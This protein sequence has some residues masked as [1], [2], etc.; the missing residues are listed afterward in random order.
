M[1]LT[2]QEE[3]QGIETSVVVIV[4]ASLHGK[5]V[6]QGGLDEPQTTEVEV[7]ANAAYLVIDHRV[8]LALAL[9]HVVMIGID[10]GCIR[11]G[12]HAQQALEGI[13]AHL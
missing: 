12:G 10:H 9:H 8:S 7:V 3:A 2:T 11:V 13:F 4:L 1:A 5:G 6:E